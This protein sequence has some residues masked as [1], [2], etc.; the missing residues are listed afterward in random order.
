M[1]KLALVVL[2]LT[3]VAMTS[4]KSGQK[5]PAYSEVNTVEKGV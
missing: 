1:K 5:C 2:V 3:V 4:C